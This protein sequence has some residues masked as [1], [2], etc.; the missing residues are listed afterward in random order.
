MAVG[1]VSVT[2]TLWHHRRDWRESYKSIEMDYRDMEDH[3]KA[4]IISY[5]VLIKDRDT[6]ISKRN[7]IIAKLEDSIM[8]ISNDME[9]AVTNYATT[10]QDMVTL[11]N[12][13]TRVLIILSGKDETIRNVTQARDDYR[14]KFEKVRRQK[15]TAESQLKRTTLII[16]SLGRDI[17]DLTKN[18]NDTRTELTNSQL[19]LAQLRNK[20]VPIATL[21]ATMPPPPI[22]GAVVAVKEDVGL[23]LIDVGKKHGVKQGY[24]FTVY[25]GSRFIA[26][27]VVEKVLHD[28]AGCRVLF[29]KSDIREGD[30]ASTILN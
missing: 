20:G 3:Y 29:R 26:K 1:Y 16:H 21:C 23:V 28:M 24:E 30:E 25:R 10:K 18:Y 14:Q 5:R 15:D 13:H 8:A 7:D 9:A 27:V 22:A 6:I 2:A 17:T 4:Q 11:L 19:I 12:D